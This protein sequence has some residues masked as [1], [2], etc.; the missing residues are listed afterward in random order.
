MFEVGQ[1][2]RLDE[3][4]ERACDDKPPF[5]IYVSD[6][7]DYKDPLAWRTIQG[8]TKACATI[9]GM[10]WRNIG[11]ESCTLLW[12]GTK[13]SCTDSILKHGL[14]PGGRPEQMSQQTIIVPSQPVDP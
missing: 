11:L 8:H 12:H 4:L 7:P 13:R 2:F 10:G 14:L 6:D 1:G 5:R 9:D 3:S